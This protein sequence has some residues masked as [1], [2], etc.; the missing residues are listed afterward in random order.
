M[1][2]VFLGRCET[3]RQE[4]VDQVIKGMFLA[5]GGISRIFQPGEKVFLKVNLLM[6]KKPEAAVTT[7]PAIVEAVA[8]QLLDAGCRVT[9]G[10]SPGGPFT[11]ILLKGLYR[12]TGMEEVASRLGCELNYNVEDITVP[13]DDGCLVKSLTLV[14]AIWE[15]DAVVSLAKLKTHGMTVFTGAVKNLFGVIPG[16]IKAEYHFKMPKQEDFSHLL[17]DICQKINPR[18]SIIDGIVGM[19]GDGPSSGTPRPIFALVGG[20]NPHAVDRIGASLIG[21]DGKKAPTLRAAEKRQLVT[22]E[23]E[24]MGASLSDLAVSGFKIPTTR[25]IHFYRGKLPKWMERYLDNFLTP[26]PLFRH[27]LCSGCQVCKNSCPPGIIT[28]KNGKPEV[29]LDR[30]IRCFCCQELCPVHAVEIKRSWLLKK[31]FR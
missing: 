26:Q 12:A 14:R 4:E 5:F 28:M 1:D 21:L 8:K 15:A 27:E 6:K 25:S 22:E 13:V 11:P 30:C 24:L 16:L 3:Y 20:I 18:F 2:K 7:H 23:V 29:D 17:V 9:I 31:V 10:D 19:E